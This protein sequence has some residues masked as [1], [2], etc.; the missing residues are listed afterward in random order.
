MKPTSIYLH[1]LLKCSRLI[2]RFSR[3]KRWN[4]NLVCAT[5]IHRSKICSNANHFSVSIHPA[6]HF[7]KA[8][9]DKVKIVNSGDKFDG[10]VDESAGHSDSMSMLWSQPELTSKIT[11]I[12]SN[13]NGTNKLL[14]D[15]F[16][17]QDLQHCNTTIIAR[18]MR[19]AGKKSRP[20]SIVLLKKYLPSIVG[21]LQALTFSSWSY[22]DIASVIYG[23]QCLSEK[24]HRY[25][26]VLSTLTEVIH[27]TLEREGTVLSNDISSMM[28][29][30]QRNTGYGEVNTKLLSAIRQLLAK[31][32]DSFQSRNVSISLYGL[33]GMSSDS[34][35]VRGL[36]SVLAAKVK[37]CRDDLNAQAVGNALYG[38]QG[39]S[40]DS[41]EV[42]GLISVLA[43]KVKGCRDDLDAQ[44]VG[45]ALYGII[46]FIGSP[47]LESVVDTIWGHIVRLCSISSNYKNLS[48]VDILCVGQSVALSLLALRNNLGQ[49]DYIQWEATS[50]LLGFELSSRFSENQVSTGFRSN[51]ER[52]M[53]TVLTR[54]F[55]KSDIAL[56]SN[57]HLF[58]LFEADIIL[59]VP[60]A[61]GDSLVINIEVDGIHHL[62]EKKIKFCFLRDGYLKSR[63][64]VVYRITAS[65]LRDMSD[66]EIQ[67]WT[68]DRV[69]SALL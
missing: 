26:S 28:Y 49:D 48:F 38:L 13:Y 54:V 68:L 27:T 60:S 40:S 44:A 2:A 61:S 16:I 47:C 67:S 32:N 52:R 42:R 43:A 51:V 9:D 22:T 18:F 64:V 66:D 12:F 33:K 58:N 50:N 3:L 37:G 39:M 63:G 11:K 1:S 4:V 21:R 56:S 24:D 35:E 62:R 36:I 53:H 65:A 15:E 55:D 29:G 14:F 30:L 19:F 59:R 7:R 31:C 34:A 69:A 17:M 45:N 20:E 5:H 10:I 25:L 6:D 57:E 23:L 41:A 46:N 8:L